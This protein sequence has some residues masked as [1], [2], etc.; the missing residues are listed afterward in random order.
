MAHGSNKSRAVNH[1]CSSLENK[2]PPGWISSAVPN[3]GHIHRDTF[4]HMPVG[5]KKSQ[6]QTYANASMKAEHLHLGIKKRE[7]NLNH[8]EK[9]KEKHPITFILTWMNWCD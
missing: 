5:E 4:I 1:C 3:G 6:A 2:L 9:C 7:S 8:P